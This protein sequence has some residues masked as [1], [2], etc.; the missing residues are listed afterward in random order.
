MGTPEDRVE[1]ILKGEVETYD[2]YLSG[3]AYQYVLY[4]LIECRSCGNKKEV[5]IDSCS[6][7]LGDINESG[8]LDN[9]PKEFEE[10]IRK[11]EYVEVRE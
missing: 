7:Y 1:A 9:I 2:H 6:G 8:I 10:K 11:G 3:N 5:V 4:E